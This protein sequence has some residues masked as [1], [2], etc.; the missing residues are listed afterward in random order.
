[1]TISTSFKREKC[2]FET[3][4]RFFIVRNEK[5]YVCIKERTEKR[6]VVEI[7]YLNYTHSH[8]EL[9]IK[10]YFMN[11]NHENVTLNDGGW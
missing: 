9:I 10:I 11:C 6:V 5:A 7:D 8:I 4:A 2:E 1:M 3:M